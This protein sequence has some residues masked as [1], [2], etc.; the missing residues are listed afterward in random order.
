MPTV[1]NTRWLRRMAAFSA[2]LCM[3]NAV[4]ANAEPAIPIDLRFGDRNAWLFTRFPD[5]AFCETIRLVTCY[6]FADGT[7][8]A[9][10]S[11]LLP[12]NQV[13]A[14][15]RLPLGGCTKVPSFGSSPDVVEVRAGAGE[16]LVVGPGTCAELPGQLA[17]HTAYLALP[18]VPQPIPPTDASVADL[19]AVLR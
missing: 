4:P 14:L 1:R 17:D 11:L 7:V 3:V 2:V 8:V 9:Q 15:A 19:S 12:V 10:V 5:M 18:G 16:V 6:R 13:L